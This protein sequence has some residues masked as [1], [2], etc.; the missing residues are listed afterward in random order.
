MN[1]KNTTLAVALLSLSAASA[2]SVD[3]LNPL[4]VNAFNYNNNTYN[5]YEV[6]IQ[7]AIEL[8]LAIANSLND[9]HQRVQEDVDMV[10][11]IQASLLSY[12]EEEKNRQDVPAFSGQIKT[13]IL[14]L[15]PAQ[16]AAGWVPDFPV[17]DNVYVALT[18]APAAPART[19]LDEIRNFNHAG[20]NKAPAITPKTAF[21]SALQNHINTMQLKHVETNDRSAPVVQSAQPKTA[22]SQEINGFN[23][24][25]L[26]KAETNDRSHA[27][28]DASD[29]NRD[30][31]R[32]IAVVLAGEKAAKEHVVTRNNLEQPAAKKAVRFRDEVKDGNLAQII[33]ARKNNR[34]LKAIE[35]ADA[36]RATRQAQWLGNVDPEKAA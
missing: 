19:F 14:H 4:D 20:L 5:S 17:R 34:D 12:Y 6:D 13:G 8:S 9:Q 2:A 36:A 22:F 35:A 32:H 30:N 18:A 28:V 27:V 7:E 29:M 1:I 23:R 16:Q 21:G 26:R 25:N 31:Q 10:V 15:T 3:V 24:A 11:A 33:A